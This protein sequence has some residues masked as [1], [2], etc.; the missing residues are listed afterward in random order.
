MPR[1]RL[2]RESGH[3][4]LGFDAPSGESVQGRRARQRSVVGPEPV[5]RDHEDRRLENRGGGRTTAGSS[6][7]RPAH[8]TS[9]AVTTTVSPATSLAVESDAIGHSNPAGSRRV[10]PQGEKWAPRQTTCRGARAAEGT[11]PEAVN[12]RD[13]N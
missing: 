9:T 4:P 7:G 8:E 10:V 12:T 13:E 2:G 1:E 11:A 3:E 5:E 6:V